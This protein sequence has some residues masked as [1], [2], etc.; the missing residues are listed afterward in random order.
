MREKRL[1][2]FNVEDMEPSE[3]SH[4]LLQMPQLFGENLT[5]SWKTKHSCAQTGNSASR[6]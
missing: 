4:T 6:Y 5:V 3:M 2:T 1:T